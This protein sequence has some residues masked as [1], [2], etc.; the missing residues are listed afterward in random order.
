MLHRLNV[1]YPHWTAD[2]LTFRPSPAVYFCI[3]WGIVKTISGPSADKMI[4]YKIEFY[5]VSFLA[6]FALPTFLQ[7]FLI[8]MLKIIVADFLE[9]G[10]W[11]SGE[12]SD[13]IIKN[14]L[15]HT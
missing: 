5:K 12:I 6:Y 4:H 7:K 9:I 8:S 15:S 11:F 1:T 3:I 10:H 2:L 14:L 13:Y